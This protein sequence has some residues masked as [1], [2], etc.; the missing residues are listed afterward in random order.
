HLI[1]RILK[2]VA[3]ATVVLVFIGGATYWYFLQRAHSAYGAVGENQRF[4]VAAG[5]GVASVAERL[6]AAGI[7]DGRLTFIIYAVKTGQYKKFQVG[8]YSLSGKLSIPEI[9]EHFV[10]GKVVPAGVRITFPEGW[11]M[12][13][14]AERLT[15]NGLAGA[16][17]LAI[18]EKPFPKWRE[19]FPFLKDLPPSAS[20]EGY[21][22][23]DTYI[24]PARATG[25]LLVNELLKNFGE[26]AA[27]KITEGLTSNGLSFHE[28]LTLASI[29][30]GEGRT[31]SD[32]KNISDVFR[33][34]L[35]I[36][37]A[38]Q[39]DATINYIHGTAKDQPTFDDLKSTSPYNTYMRVGLP[40]GPIG[41]P[42][43]MSINA[44]LYPTSN[45]YF[46]FLI[47]PKT[48]ITYFAED[49]DGHQRNR[50]AYGL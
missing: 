25:E 10:D 31:E 6:E 34:R 47:D 30:E 3:V 16:D 5:E 7:I 37:Q 19:R 8:E 28:V 45:P 13:E 1:V 12:K 2:A 18:A 14:M 39:S 33:K 29:V 26:K 50:A 42:S 21:L 43:L 9:V 27:P 4:S 22:F 20:L 46:Y 38:F 15:A 11:T 49:F 36:G 17:F 32:R 35:A 41:N 40:P 44:T 24:F 23:P 48:R